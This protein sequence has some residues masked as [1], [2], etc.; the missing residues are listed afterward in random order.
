MRRR[1]PLVVALGFLLTWLP[2]QLWIHSFPRLS[3]A[4]Y[5]TG[6]TAG[7]SWIDAA[8]GPDADVTIVWTGNNPYRGWE[9]EFWNRSVNHAYDLGSD[10][11]IAGAGRAAADG[12]GTH[13][14]PPRSRQDGARAV[15]P[16]GQLGSDLGRRRSPSDEGRGL[17][18]LRVN[19]LLRTSTAITGWYDD[20]WTGPTVTW[21]RRG[22][23]RGVLRVP[24]HSDPT[25]FPS[26][27]QQIAVS[28]S[29]TPFVFRLQSS[30][31]AKTIVVPLQPQGGVCRIQ[32]A[33]SPTRR[34]LDYPALNNTDPRELGMLA[35]GF[36]YV[37]APGGEDRRRRLAA[38]AS[39]HRRRQLHPRLAPRPRR[40]RR[41][42]GR[43]VRAGEPARPARRSRAR[44][45]GS[46][47]SAGSPC[48]PPRTPLRT[49]WSRARPSARRACR[50]PVRR[51]PLQRL[52][53]PA[54][55]RRRPL[56]DDPRP[57]PAALS[58]SG[59]TRGRGACT[60]RSTSTPLARATS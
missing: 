11:L 20:T 32:F 13:R 15:R 37:P 36:E 4:A 46:R 18:L 3:S 38:L 52:D 16:R 12:A 27:V 57:R 47:S 41:A 33:I 42:R 10:S 23:V 26:I 58:R 8:V 53:V 24:V 54:A 2:L 1:F 40:G 34:P 17:V 21:L 29:T 6:I 51:P 48:F 59:C 28:G 14:V 49:A 9:N 5:S 55:A 43:R 60:V 50:R 44:S 22:C 56:D 30:A 39:A 25:L 19:G 31:A 7:K 35:S 45:T